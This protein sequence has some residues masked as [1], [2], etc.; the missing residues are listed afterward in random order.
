MPNSDLIKIARDAA[1][2]AV[3]ETLISAGIEPEIITLSEMKKLYGRK[4]AG[5]A[6][7]SEDIEWFAGARKGSGNM[8]YCKRTEFRR[9]LFGK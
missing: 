9:F 8:A 3:G 5:N 6:R 4:L 1:I 2:I 7:I